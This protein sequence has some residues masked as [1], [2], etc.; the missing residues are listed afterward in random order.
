MP[1][2]PY[3]LDAL[4]PQISRETMEYHY[5]KHLKGY[6]DRLNELIPGTRYEN[7]SLED[8]IKHADG[9]IFNNGAQVW[10]HTF[11]FFT[12]SPN[13]KSVPTGALGDAIDRD[14]GSFDEFKKQMRDVAVT[15]F[16]SGY[17][18]LVKDRK[19]RLQIIAESNAGNPMRDGYTVLA[20]LDVW[21]HAY[22]IDYRN[23]RPE[24]V[25]RHMERIDWRVVE[26]RFL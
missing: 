18:W 4:A 23:R 7:A 16:G 11:L 22:Y 24:A 14:F 5:G 20:G 12:L 13:P 9:P 15:L 10:N 8:I 3:D 21:E 1:T 19:D 26:E 2:L 25:D 17:A 6:V